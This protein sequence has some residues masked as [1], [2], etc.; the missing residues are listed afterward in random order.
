MSHCLHSDESI[1]LYETPLIPIALPEKETTM[2]LLTS[3]PTALANGQAAPASTLKS[4][5]VANCI[6]RHLLLIGDLPLPSLYTTPLK[7]LIPGI[8][9]RV[10]ANPVLN[11]HDDPG[12]LTSLLSALQQSMGDL[13]LTDI[14]TH[15]L[16]DFAKSD[17]QLLGEI[18]GAGVALPMPTNDSS[19]R[20]QR[21]AAVKAL[22][23]A[24]PKATFQMLVQSPQSLSSAAL[25][26]LN[27]A[28]RSGVLPL[29]TPPTP[30]P[31]VTLAN[32][33]ISFHTNDED[34]D[35]DTHVTIN[36]LDDNNVN[37]A[38]LDDDFGHF[39]DNSD[40]GPFALNV[41]NASA[42]ADIQ[43]GNITI[44]IDP[45]GH[46]TWRFNFFLDM[47]FS[48]GTHFSATENGLELTQN[49]RQQTFGLSGILRQE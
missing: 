33:T 30:T 22:T 18:K 21:I 4:T 27:D 40:E 37:C 36:V 32:C 13:T 39:N 42:I 35:D 16:D 34:K 29:K 19:V 3:K 47:Q 45:N 8:L 9:A 15:P 6:Q 41:Q 12:H 31:T 49:R 20:S 48:D 11:V 23:A 28:K 38:H 2:T 7:D 25:S 26:S 5:Y 17:L 24:A 46:D 10:Q 14:A 44:R 43:R 1:L